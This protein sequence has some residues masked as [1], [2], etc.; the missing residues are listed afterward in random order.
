[1]ALEKCWRDMRVLEDFVWGSESSKTWE[2][3]EK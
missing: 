1:M 3:F 2:E